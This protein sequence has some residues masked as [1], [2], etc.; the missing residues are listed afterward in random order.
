[1]SFLELSEFYRN[2][3]VAGIALEQED[4]KKMLT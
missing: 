1:M 4:V 3:A 2:I